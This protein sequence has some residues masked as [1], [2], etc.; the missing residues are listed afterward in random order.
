M[1]FRIEPTRLKELPAPRQT[2]FLALFQS[3]SNQNLCVCQE[4]PVKMHFFVS[5]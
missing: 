3:L 4:D 5:V 2:L 1:L